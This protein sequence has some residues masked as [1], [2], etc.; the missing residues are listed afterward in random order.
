ME[1]QRLGETR[2]LWVAGAIRAA[3]LSGQY[4]PGSPLPSEQRLSTQYRCG[5]DTVRAALDV[6]RGEGLAVKARGYPTLVT[7]VTNPT[8]VPLEA[9]ATIGARMPLRPETTELGCRPEVPL[10]IVTT[11][12]GRQTRH[13]A[14]RTLLAAS[15]P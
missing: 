13:P 4:P 8:A 14:D 6:L 11:T 7:P 12:D 2:Y 10:L 15:P 1:I 9:G 3:I 5:R